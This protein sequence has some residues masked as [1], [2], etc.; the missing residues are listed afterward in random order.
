MTG[1]CMVVTKRCRSVDL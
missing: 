1:C